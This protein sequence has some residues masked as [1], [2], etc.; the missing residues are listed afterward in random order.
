MALKVPVIV[1]LEKVREK[2]PSIVPVD[3]V[4]TLVSVIVPEVARSVCNWPEA[5]ALE[6]NKPAILVF[7]L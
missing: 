7:K 6:A 5:V 1:P 3:E 4:S 2:L